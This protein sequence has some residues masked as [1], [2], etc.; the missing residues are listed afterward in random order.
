MLNKF[1]AIGNLGQ[2]VELR[3]TSNGKKV[4][5]FSLAVQGAKNDK[6][7]ATEWI[8]CVVW[9]TL[10]ENCAKYLHKGSKCYLEGRLQTRSWDDK[11]GQK[12][13]TT[14]C[15]AYD[16]KFLDPKLDAHKPEVQHNEPTQQTDQAADIPF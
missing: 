5:S 15:V 14:E 7:Y 4:G 9:E 1:C 11:Q 10:A 13:Y 8:N 16:V 12:R 2:D 6:G 3:S